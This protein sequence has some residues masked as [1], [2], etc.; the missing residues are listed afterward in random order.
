MHTDIPTDGSIPYMFTLVYTYISPSLQAYNQH[1]TFCFKASEC[2]D[3]A[4]YHSHQY[5]QH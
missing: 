2:A 3:V 5:P 4:G 1:L